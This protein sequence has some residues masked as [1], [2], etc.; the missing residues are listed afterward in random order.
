M[1]STDPRMASPG[2][3]QSFAAMDIGEGI[4]PN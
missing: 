1:V 2:G 3:K 4:T